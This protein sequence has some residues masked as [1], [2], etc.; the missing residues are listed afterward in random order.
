MIGR[1]AIASFTACILF[2]LAPIVRAEDAPARPPSADAKGKVYAAKAADGL[3]YLYWVPPDYDK[4]KGANLLFIF[5]GSNLDRRWGFANHEPGKF[6]PHD[7]I[8][9]PDG[10]TPNGEGGFNFRQADKDMN[11]VHALQLEL[12]LIFKLKATYLYGHSQG[13]FFA[14]L[15]AGQFNDDVD[16]VLGQAGGV[17][18]GT[19]GSTK[20]HHQAIAIMHGTAD[21]V[22]P[23]GNSVGA[24]KFFEEKG[25]PNVHLRALKDWNHW[26]SAPQ[27]AQQLAWCEGMTAK[28][29]DV[30]EAALN[31]MLAVKEG[32]DHVARWTL[33]MRLVDMPFITDAQKAFARKAAGDS[34]ELVARH[35]AAI[36]KSLGKNPG[37]KLDGKPWLGH[38]IRFRQEFAGIA[39]ADAFLKDWARKIDDQ[40]KRADEA[41]KDYFAKMEKEPA[42]AFLSGVDVVARGFLVDGYANRELLDQLKK[43]KEDKALKLPKTSHTYWEKVV[44]LWEDAMSK[45]SKEFDEVGL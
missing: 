13:A 8:V 44:P 42:K 41:S 17:W 33:A 6:R 43:W 37:D 19:T 30:S 31:E 10:T 3:D 23:F 35:V 27:A 14:F 11:R 32:Q 24:L 2:A 34:E 15:Y 38:L 18:I 12:R 1:T 28:D 16:G 45:G 40:R 4:S 39:P 7:I 29:P 22:V 5:H 21:P 26:P 25:Y 36:Q 20:H 9:C